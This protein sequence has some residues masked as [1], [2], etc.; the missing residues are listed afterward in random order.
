MCG[1]QG[2]DAR[3]GIRR[4]SEPQPRPY[5]NR[6]AQPRTKSYLIRG[7]W[8]KRVRRRNDTSLKIWDVQNAVPRRGGDRNLQISRLHGHG[9]GTICSFFRALAKIERAGVSDYE[10][11]YWQLARREILGGEIGKWP[12]GTFRP[13]VVRPRNFSL[14]V[15]ERSYPL[16]N[17]TYLPTVTGKQFAGAASVD[18]YYLS[19]S[20]LPLQ[21][22][23]QVFALMKTMRAMCRQ[24][25]QSL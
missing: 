20:P 11:I 9:A 7:K 18:Q 19:F 4:Q 5:Q 15:E 8:V 12:H 23:A 1:R 14:E 25:I 2:D 22:Q 6:G 10:L 24:P 16:S 3:P 21:R 17:L 13:T